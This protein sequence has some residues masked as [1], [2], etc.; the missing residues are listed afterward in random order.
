LLAEESLRVAAARVRAE[1]HAMPSPAEVV[2]RI[3]KN[4]SGQ[5]S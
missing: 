2:D 1:I 4:F 5:I 3:T